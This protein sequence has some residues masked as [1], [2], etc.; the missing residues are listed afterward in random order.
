MP[1]D[2]KSDHIFYQRENMTIEV[3]ILGDQLWAGQ[4]ALASYTEE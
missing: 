1:G 2:N 4:S 3:W